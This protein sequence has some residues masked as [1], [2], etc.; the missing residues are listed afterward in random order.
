MQLLA[1]ESKTEHTASRPR[2]VDL[3]AAGEQFWEGGH[4]AKS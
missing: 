1:V 2:T 4:D 3:S